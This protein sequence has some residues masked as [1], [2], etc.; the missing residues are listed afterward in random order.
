MHG[1]GSPEPTIAG[2]TDT[3]GRSEM[4]YLSAQW[5]KLGPSR[6]PGS[7]GAVSASCSEDG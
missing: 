7:A 5:V 4:D 2:T 1:S 6:L 3:I